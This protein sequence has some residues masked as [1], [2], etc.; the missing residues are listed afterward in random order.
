MAGILLPRVSPAQ[1]AGNVI[2]EANEQLFCIMAALNMAG[3]DA[4]MGNDSA[5]TARRDVRALL[6]KKSLP[7]LPQ[8][9]KF[10]EAHRVRDDSG[11]DLGQYVSL[12][13][14]LDSP[15]EFRTI[16]PATDLPPDAK[17][18]LGLIPL[19]KSFYNQAGLGGLWGEIQPRS[20]AEIE[21]YTDAVRK[22]I[23]LADA[24]LRFPSGAYLG[25]TYAIYL[26][27]LAAPEQ[28][29]ARIYGA[30]YYLVVT[31]SKEPK[32]SEIRHQYL[33]FLLD[34][35]A[36]KYAAEIHQKAE[37][38][39]IARQAE[40]LGRDFKEDFPLLATECLIRAAELRMDKRSKAELGKAVQEL[41]ASGLILVPYFNEALEDF[42]QQESSMNV[43]YKPMILG[44][45]L[46]QERKRLAPVKFTVRPQTA[47]AP[48]ATQL[49]EEQ[50]AL[51]RGDNLI[52]DG[53][54]NDAKAAFQSVLEKS[55]A[56][57][58]ALYG[59]AVVAANT[60][61]PDLA[62]EYFLKTLDGARDLRIVTWSHIYLGR[63]YDIKGK[64]DD[65]LAQYRAASL[66]S[67]A[68]PD[69]ARAV[70]NGLSQPF[71]SKQH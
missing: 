56:S 69:A 60:R 65:A 48:Q 9:S 34:P 20:Q 4:G 2:L 61:K 70:Q 23:V 55:P 66:T 29:H 36:A 15:P 63:L 58:R 51:D 6:G 14:L 59:L 38:Q 28:V 54:Y 1:Q 27:L 52:A 21:R 16:V 50:R 19:L 39:G 57:E 41:T 44:V 18:L 67:T 62:E 35:L 17:R 71:G 31:P 46:R 49:S 33:H 25:R 12:A 53:R 11:A 68:Y 10:Y 40:E 64:R 43:F 42:E 13:L 8:L 22:S 32:L 24:Y 3:Y 26:D 37:L 47:P 7:V 45:D 30:N 5:N